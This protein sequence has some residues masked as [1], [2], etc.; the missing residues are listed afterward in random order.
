MTPTLLAS[1]IVLV[2]LA[3]VPTAFLLYAGHRERRWEESVA[4]QVLL[5]DTI[6]RELG[7]V[8]APTVTRGAWRRWDIAIPVPL[9]RPELT[10]AI[11]GI[12]ELMFP[13][14]EGPMRIVLTRSDHMRAYPID[15]G[16]GGHRTEKRQ[17]VA[18]ATRAA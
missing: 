6:H 3:L 2:T 17:P 10:A 12:V 5:T 13:E 18:P 8:A 7:A 4:R 15:A 9:D 14:G 11:V 1:L 16:R